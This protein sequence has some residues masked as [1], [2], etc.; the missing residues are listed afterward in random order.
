MAQPC[1]LPTSSTHILVHTIIPHF[2]GWPEWSWRWQNEGWW[3]W[4][5]RQQLWQ[6]LPS[7]ASSFGLP[8]AASQGGHWWV[9]VLFTPC[10]ACTNGKFTS[11]HVSSTFCPLLAAFSSTPH[12]SFAHVNEMCFSCFSLTCSWCCTSFSHWWWGWA[13]DS[14]EAGLLGHWERWSLQ[15]FI[16]IPHIPLVLS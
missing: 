4:Q 14:A 3:L 6:S 12:P 2:P 8:C 7:G 1:M 13:W 15:H 11:W 9:C 5:Q 16:V 10:G